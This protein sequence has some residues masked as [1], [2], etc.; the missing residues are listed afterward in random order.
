MLIM[1]PILAFV[2]VGLLAWAF[3]MPG[4]ESMEVRLRK[5]GY[6]STNR[7]VADLEK[8]FSERVISP[9]IDLIGV[10]VLKITPD[11]MQQHTKEKLEQA[12]LK[13][14]PTNFLIFMAILAV[15]LPLLFIMP[16]IRGGHFGPRE[17]MIGLVMFFLGVRM[18]DFWLSR[19]I[20]A[21]QEKIRKSL[22][23]ALDVITICVEA[24]YGL[25]AALHKVAEKTQGPL[26]EELKT[27]LLQ[28]N[29]GKPRTQA[30]RDMA[31]RTKVADLQAFIAT[32]IQAEQMGVSIAGILR[33]QSDSMRIKRRQRAEEQAMKAPIKML[34][35]LVLFILPAMFVVILG[36]AGLR[37]M[38][39]LSGGGM[40]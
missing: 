20:T 39:F 4:T 7:Q 19:K 26:A 15:G 9:L 35:P 38:T 30:L 16:A 5:H 23:D 24:G 18:P 36:P 3:T 22:A 29:L 40:K 1:L 12:Q 2:T 8:P 10:L 25:D 34:F 32:I 17:L 21:R 31:L 28:I 13:I 11:R 37:I 14:K 27:T 33:V 6:M